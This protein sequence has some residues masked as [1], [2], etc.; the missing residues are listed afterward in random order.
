ME[1][2]RLA[3]IETLVQGRYWVCEGLTG[4]K[5]P[6][7]VGFHGYGE[8]AEIL[9]REINLIPGVT[10]W[11]RIAIQ[12]LHP[13]YNTRTREVVASW[14]TRLDR[15]AAIRNNVRYVAQVLDRELGS[16][17]LQTPLVY[18]GFSQGTAMAFR[19]AAGVDRRCQ[20]VVALGGDVPP[21][22]AGGELSELPV[23][24]LGR[25]S[26]DEWYSEDKLLH[27]LEVL[28]SQGVDARP[29]RFDGGHEWTDGF[30][31]TVGRFLEGLQPRSAE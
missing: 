26:R 18:T 27:D 25:G 7:L 3:S 2:S 13:F 9:L 24:L 19:A 22:L 11:K 6:V 16:G 15:D 20:A 30:R 31:G 12:G 28:K 5:S 4:S 23:A 8:D 1:A 14:M 21:D 29:V 17:N 10:A